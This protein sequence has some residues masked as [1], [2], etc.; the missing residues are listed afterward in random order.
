MTKRIIFLGIDGVL[1]GIDFLCNIYYEGVRRDNL[2]GHG[3][4]DPNKVSLLNTLNCYGVEIVI[5]S[6]WG[7]SAVQPLKELGLEIPIVGVTKHHSICKSWICRGNEIDD[8]IC[9]HFNETTKYGNDIDG[10]EYVILDD[11]SDMLLGQLEHFIKV[12]PETALTGADIE[13][14]KKILKIV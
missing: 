7:D 12:D 6:S 1:A 10:V 14:I 4:I 9:E 2:P 3:F 8:Y 11:D 13:R 5:S